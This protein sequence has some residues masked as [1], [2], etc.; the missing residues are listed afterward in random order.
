MRVPSFA[1]IQALKTHICVSPFLRFLLSGDEH[2]GKINFANYFIPSWTVFTLS[3]KDQ[4][5]KDAWF[6]YAKE[7]FSETSLVNNAVLYLSSLF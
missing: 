3:G 7:S 6:F 1:V 2:G 5:S 4:A